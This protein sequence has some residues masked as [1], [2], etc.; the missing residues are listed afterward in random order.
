MW[1]PS[2]RGWFFLAGS[3]G[4]LKQ[5]K[6]R[7]VEVEGKDSETNNYNRD[8]ANGH[9]AHPSFSCACHV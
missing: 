3:V 7:A 8:E 4:D 2:L 9:W 6:P 5:R 1:C